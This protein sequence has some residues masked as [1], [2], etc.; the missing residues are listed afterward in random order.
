MI[1]I[2][3]FFSSSARRSSTK[4]SHES[5]PTVSVVCHVQNGFFSINISLI[6]G[7]N[8][9]PEG[10]RSSFWLF[11]VNSI[12]LNFLFFNRPSAFQTSSNQSRHLLFTTDTILA[13]ADPESFFFRT[14]DTLYH[15]LSRI[16]FLVFSLRR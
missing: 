5:S 7:N 13:S 3:F 4:I 16:Y 6:L 9:H 14:S 11:L 2:H 15:S 8:V 12:N 1:T 10:L